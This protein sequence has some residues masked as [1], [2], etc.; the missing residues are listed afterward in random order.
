MKTLI[1]AGGKGTRMGAFTADLAKP[2]A[3]VAGKPI[4]EYQIELARRYGLSDIEMLTGFRGDLIE[5]YFGDG[6]RFG[7]DIRYTHER[8]PLGTAGAVRAIAGRL[9]EDFVVFYGDVMMD[10]DLHALLRFHRER[11]PAATIVVHPNDHPFDSDLVAVDGEDRVTAMY[12]KPHSPGSDHRNLVSAALYVLSPS[13]LVDVREGVASDFGQD[14]LPQLVACGA[15]VCAY[16]TREY[17]KDIGTM[18]RLEEVERDVISGRT[19]RFNGAN[20]VGAIFLDRDGVLNRDDKPVTTPNDVELL[21]AVA[22]AVKAINRGERLTVVVSNQPLVAKGFTTEADLERIHARLETLVGAD[23]AYFDRIYYCPH[24]PERGHAGERPELKIVCDCRKPGIGMITRAVQELNLDLAD[25][26]IIGDSTVDVQTGINAGLHTVLVRTGCAGGD[27]TCVCDPDFVFDDVAQA[28]EFVTSRYPALFRE[29]RTLLNNLL[30]DR[31]RRLVIAVGGLSRSGKSTL[32]AVL[33]ITLK[34]RGVRTSCLRL[35]QWIVDAGKRAPAS[36]VRERYR[37]AEIAH[38]VQQLVSG[39]RIE[40]HRYGAASRGSTRHTESLTL[41]EGEV[42]IVDGV[43]ALDVPAIVELSDLRVYVESPEPMR[44]VRFAAF[45]QYK[46]LAS[47]AIDALYLDRQVDE[48]PI[49]LASRAHAH[50]VIN[51]EELP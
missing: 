50:R 26:F 23:G 15:R 42:L 6:R 8:E 17:I 20:R 22:G 44:K 27:G 35:D 11:S 12:G 38:A 1:L 37:Y 13:A 33:M 24:H 9:L 28:V 14:I 36:T 40:M 19:A 46:G 30:A 31:A 3:L 48:T 18:L 2:M 21:P 43:V 51:I 39:E 34:Q 7:V 10:V 41:G 16:N 25:S 5:A 49:V 29:A 47:E 32:A 4:L 45:Y